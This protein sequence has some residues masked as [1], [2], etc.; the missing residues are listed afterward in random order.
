MKCGT[1]SARHSRRIAISIAL[2]FAPCQPL[3][4]IRTV[5]MEDEKI[6]DTKKIT[7]DILAM[8]REMNRSWTEG[9][10]EEQFRV[11]IH[12]DAIAI[13]PSIH[14]K[15][16]GQDAYVAGWQGFCEA[17]VIHE[18]RE[19]D[20]TVQIYAGGKAAVVTYLFTIKFETGGRK[21]T[22]QGRDMFFLVKEGRRWLV[23]SDQFSPEP[24]QV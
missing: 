1:L 12:K 11:F 9:W 14:G 10:H 19:M 5:H 22:M 18:W 6:M 17:S 7:D 4:F 21:V 8:V 3:P 24:F 20:H 13:V 16:V 2:T 23:A 15:L